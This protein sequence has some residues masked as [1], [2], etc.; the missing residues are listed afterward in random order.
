MRRREALRQHWRHFG[1]ILVIGIVTAVGAALLLPD[2]VSD[3]AVGAIAVS[4]L[5]VLSLIRISEPTRPY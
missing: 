5:W 2:E 1:I 3:F 4:T